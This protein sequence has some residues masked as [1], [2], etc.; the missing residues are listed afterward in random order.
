MGSVVTF[1][2]RKVYSFYLNRICGGIETIKTSSLQPRTFYKEYHNFRCSEF[3]SRLSECLH[4]CPL[5]ERRDL[6]NRFHTQRIPLSVSHGI[7]WSGLRKW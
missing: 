3:L 6:S 4:Q 5:Q 1:V 7:Y 2:K